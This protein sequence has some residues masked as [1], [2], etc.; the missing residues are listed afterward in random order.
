MEV[1]IGIIVFMAFI[2]F[3]GI[4]GEPFLKLV[5]LIEEA[6]IGKEN[7][8][9]PEPPKPPKPPKPP[10]IPY[11]PTEFVKAI[12]MWT[13]YSESTKEE[14]LLNASNEDVLSWYCQLRELSTCCKRYLKASE[15]NRIESVRL[16]CEA[17]DKEMDGRNLNTI[18]NR[19]QSKLLKTP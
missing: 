13:T 11:E 14:I 2:V 6:I 18:Q 16:F 1:V 15:D 8:K 7:K 9:P 5:L 10:P 19:A 12:C 17:V 3:L 4:I